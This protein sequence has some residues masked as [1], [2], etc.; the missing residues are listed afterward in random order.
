[1]RFLSVYVQFKNKPV[2][3]RAIFR[4]IKY[5]ATVILYPFILSTIQLK[6]EVPEIRY[7]VAHV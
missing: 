6:L 4:T 3:G 2:Y 5:K 7:H 1:M